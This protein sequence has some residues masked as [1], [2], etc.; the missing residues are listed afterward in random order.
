MKRW[1]RRFTVAIVFVISTAVV[2]VP[3]AL[4]HSWSID[5]D[6]SW[7]DVDPYMTLAGPQSAWTFHN[8]DGTCHVDGT[9][10]SGVTPTAWANWYL[11]VTASYNHTYK[12]NAGIDCGGA[13][14]HRSSY[15]LYRM[16]VAGTSGGYYTESRNQRNYCTVMSLDTYTFTAT[17]GGYVRLVNTTG[18]PNCVGQK[19]QVD[20]MHW[21]Q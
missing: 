3:F 4:A 13:S 20:S 7:S 21:N 1:I 8:V 14:T 19:F 10:I 9:L 16:Y 2:Q 15:V 11:P 5:N 18:C 6:C 12:V 17:S